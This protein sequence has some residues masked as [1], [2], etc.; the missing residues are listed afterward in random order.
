MT[1]YQK[2][3]AVA[4]LFILLIVFQNCGKAATSTPST[5]AGN[6]TTYDGKVFISAG[7]CADGTN[8]KSEIKLLSPNSAEITRENCAAV[9]PRTVTLDAG[10]MP[11]NPSNVAAL[12]T[13]FDEYGSTKPTSLFCRGEESRVYT[14]GL[15]TFVEDAVLQTS[16]SLSGQVK[17]GMYGPQ[18]LIQGFESS[19][20]NFTS[21][22]NPVTGLTIYHGEDATTGQAADIVIRRQGNIWT[23]NMLFRFGPQDSRPP[24]FDSSTDLSGYSVPVRCFER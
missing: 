20:M 16:P 5:K 14:D 9:P 6:G 11:H 12:E 23:G 21:V 15:R 17:A 22:T 19:S 2:F 3:G 24:S 13:V 7:N 8:V 4:S 18:G 10:F 1:G